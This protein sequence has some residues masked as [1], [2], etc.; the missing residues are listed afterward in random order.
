MPS[1]VK[2]AV[3]SVPRSHAK[4]QFVAPAPLMSPWL[5]P[6]ST[7]QCSASAGV[8]VTGF[9]A[10]VQLT[11]LPEVIWTVGSGKLVMRRTEAA[12]RIH[13]QRDLGQ[14]VRALAVRPAAARAV[15]RRKSSG[16]TSAGAPATAAAFGVQ[17]FGGSAA[18]RPSLGSSKVQT[19]AWIV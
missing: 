3:P 8:V 15:T 11:E 1:I 12:A 18:A 2:G 5:T 14:A 17:A 7:V 9:R 16:L 10:A 13:D 19:D 6:S 4:A